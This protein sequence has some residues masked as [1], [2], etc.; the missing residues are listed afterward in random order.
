MKIMDSLL[1]ADSKMQFSRSSDYYLKILCL[2]F[3]HLSPQELLE[4][5]NIPFIGTC[6][7]ECR[8]AFD[9]VRLVQWSLPMLLVFKRIS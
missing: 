8:K 2:F 5:L 1:F 4:G 7:K 3:L 9:K 6:T